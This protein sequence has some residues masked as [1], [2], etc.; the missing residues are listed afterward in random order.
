MAMSYI[1]N[2]GLVTGDLYG[3]TTTCQPY[4]LPSCDHHIANSSNPC[5]SQIAAT[6]SCVK[7]CQSSYNNTYKGDKWY[8]SQAYKVPNNVAKI[9]TEIMTYGSV[10]A[11]FTVYEDFLSYTGGV[12]QY[13][14]GQALGGHAIKIIGWGVDATTNVP[15]W[16]C[17][18]SWNTSWGESGFFRILSGQNEC[19]IEGSIVTVIAD[20]PSSKK[21]AKHIAMKHLKHKIRK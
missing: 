19:G 20:I 2:K 7:N 13:T 16:L 18:N 17:T 21:R 5:P 8:A 15:Y 3:D 11:S 12:Y 14:T 10:E 4:F 1:K 9:Q 6:P